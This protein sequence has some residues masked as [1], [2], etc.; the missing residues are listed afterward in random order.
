MTPAA[1][2][3]TY[4]RWFVPVHNE[5]VYAKI[6]GCDLVTAKLRGVSHGPF[7]RKGW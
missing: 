4:K 7:A 5:M 1:V 2:C 6:D 3:Y